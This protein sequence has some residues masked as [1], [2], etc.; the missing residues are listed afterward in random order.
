M[1]RVIPELAAPAM[2]IGFELMTCSARNS[3]VFL[4]QS[5]HAGAAM[6]ANLLAQD[7]KLVCFSALL[8]LL[9]MLQRYKAA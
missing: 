8:R 9:P 6:P 1:R 5:N 2:R 7:S 4:V 3:L